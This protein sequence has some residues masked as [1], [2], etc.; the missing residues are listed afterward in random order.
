MIT[1]ASLYLLLPHLAT[2]PL[3]ITQ[4]I[5][6]FAIYS[7]GGWAYE[8]IVCSIGERR[9]VKRGFLYGPTCPI[10][11]VGAVSVYLLLG[12]IQDPLALFVMGCVVATG[13]EY[14]TATLLENVFHQRWWS[15]DGWFLNVKGRICLLGSLVFGGLTLLAVLVLQPMI[16]LLVNSIPVQQQF[17]LAALLALVYLYDAA[18]SIEHANPDTSHLPQRAR[19]VVAALPARMPSPSELCLDARGHIIERAQE[20]KGFA[21]ER[22]DSFRRF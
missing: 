21:G 14:A 22:F 10:Y 8:T 5:L 13:I 17:F 20:A 15:Y 12:W 4:L 3:A 18:E 1:P 19:R 6:W 11:G 16:I 2:L 7:T 9:L